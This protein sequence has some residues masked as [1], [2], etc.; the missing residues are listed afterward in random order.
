MT[1]SRKALTR[2]VIAGPDTLGPG[3]S[4]FGGGGSGSGGP[5]GSN[6][7]NAANPGYTGA[8]PSPTPDTIHNWKCPIC[9]RSQPN[10][11][12]L[13]DHLWDIHDVRDIG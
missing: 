12:D 1:L 7:S 10:G 6:N 4:S 11:S 13:R 5:G 3:I 9:K 2:K 8:P